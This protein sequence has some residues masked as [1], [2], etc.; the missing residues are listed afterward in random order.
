MSIFKR[1]GKFL[2]DEQEVSK[3]NPSAPN[4][5]SR[6]SEKI[7]SIVDAEDSQMKI[8]KAT[9][10]M[11]EALYFKNVDGCKDKHILVWLDTDTTTFYSYSGFEL[12]LQSYWNDEKGYMFKQVE[13]KHGNPGTEARKVDVHVRS[14]D[15]YIQEI[16]E[17]I[18][19]KPT[20]H[21]AYIS[22]YNNK[23]SL[24]KNRY[25]LSSEILEHG[26]CKYYNIGRGEFPEM[27][28]GGYRHNFIA[29]D[30]EKNLEINQY[31]SRAHAH[32]GFSENIG[33]YLQ[34]ENGGSRLYGNRTRI[35]RDEEKIEI[36][37]VDSKESLHNGDLIELGKSVILKYTEI[38]EK[39]YGQYK[40]NV[41]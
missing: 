24:L 2:S 27:D 38:E 18:V 10:A 30:D 5:N 16:Q 26:S 23:G 21:K 6:Q 17:N 9:L 8:K 11:L 36:E 31:V 33:F 12:E 3:G 15:V 28:S 32:I 20:I 1:L 37:N 19:A 7:D 22:I 39:N 4:N 41:E 40:R 34:V 35:F 13:I 29:I 25:V 14:I